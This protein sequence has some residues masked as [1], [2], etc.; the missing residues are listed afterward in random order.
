MTFRS[1]ELHMVVYTNGDFT[2]S[3]RDTGGSHERAIDSAAICNGGQHGHL[4]LQP[5]CRGRLAAQN[6][7]YEGREEDISVH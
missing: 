3:R 5:H 1:S 6:R 7:I 4:A 2:I